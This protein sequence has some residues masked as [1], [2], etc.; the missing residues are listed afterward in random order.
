V[1][2][3]VRHRPK[4]WPRRPFGNVAGSMG[5]RKAFC[6]VGSAAT[7]KDKSQNLL[8]ELRMSRSPFSVIGGTAL[9]KELLFGGWF[10]WLN[11]ADF[12]VGGL[13]GFQ[14]FLQRFV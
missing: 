3:Q 4:A 8:G 12:P 9:P 13:I 1:R 11:F 14:I 6:G 5:H 10:G 7:E 2:N